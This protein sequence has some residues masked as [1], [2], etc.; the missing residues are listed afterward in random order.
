MS[1][2]KRNSTVASLRDFFDF[3]SVLTG[4]HSELE[5]ADVRSS[6]LM[7]EF[8]RVLR[9]ESRSLSRTPELKTRRKISVYP[10][11]RAP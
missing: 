11:K 6:W 2:T 7:V 8:H 10:V 9:V 4:E 3:L 1:P 5:L